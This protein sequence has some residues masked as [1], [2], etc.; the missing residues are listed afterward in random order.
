MVTRK[1]YL[2]MFLDERTHPPSIVSTTALP[3]RP[4]TAVKTARA[5]ATHSRLLKQTSGLKPPSVSSA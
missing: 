5:N 1:A 4:L 2:K 3:T